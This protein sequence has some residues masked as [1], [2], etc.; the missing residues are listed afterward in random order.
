MGHSNHSLTIWRLMPRAWDSFFEPTIWLRIFGWN[1]CSIRIESFVAIIQVTCFPFGT[2]LWNHFLKHSFVETKLSFNF[3]QGSTKHYSPLVDFF[4]D[5]SR[6]SQICSGILSPQKNDNK[7]EVDLLEGSSHLVVNSLTT[8]KSWDDIPSSSHI[9]GCV[10]SGELTYPVKT[11]L[12][13]DDF[14]FPV[15]WDMDEPFLGGYLPHKSHMFFLGGGFKYF[16]FSP[17]FGEDSHFD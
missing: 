17:L 11:Q 14:P 8:Y 6:K 7:H 1:F 10:P 15:W 13:V 5:L 2:H 16:L 9:P 3:F 4:E 12:W